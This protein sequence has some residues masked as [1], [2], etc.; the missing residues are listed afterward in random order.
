MKT[1][2]IK[3]LFRRFEGIVCEYNGVECWSARELQHLLGYTKWDKFVNVI[4]KAK[5]ACANAGEII[6]NHFPQVEK[7]V[8]IGS[9][10]E[11]MIFDVLLTRYALL[12]SC[13]KWRF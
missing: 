5:G 9:G 7:M 11:R 10:A 6:E 13:A 1:E 2:E 8:V 3:D 4:D 12:F